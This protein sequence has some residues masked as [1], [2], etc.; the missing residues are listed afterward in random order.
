MT[1]RNQLLRKHNKKTKKKQM[2]KFNLRKRHGKIKKVDDVKI[3]P[4]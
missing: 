3:Q 1:V 2:K 4:G